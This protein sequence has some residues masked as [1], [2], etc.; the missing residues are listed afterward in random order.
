[1]GV[2][3]ATSRA[4]ALRRNYTRSIRRCKYKVCCR[5]HGLGVG[6]HCEAPVVEVH[7]AADGHGAAK[8]GAIGTERL[9]PILLTRSVRGTC[10]QH[11]DLPMALRIPRP[12]SNPP[13]RN[14]NIDAAGP[15]SKSPHSGAP[16]WTCACNN[17]ACACASP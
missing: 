9:A 12:Q 2:P 3:R 10:P 7:L 4:H 8:N 11:E 14:A 5:A 15:A 6:E 13:E 16:S 1:M 17:S